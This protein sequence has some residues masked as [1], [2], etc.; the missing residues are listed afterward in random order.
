[1]GL[2]G[3]IKAAVDPWDSDENITSLEA[4]QHM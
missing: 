4:F 2:Q 3:E 1:M